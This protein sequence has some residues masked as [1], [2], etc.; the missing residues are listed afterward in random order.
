MNNP[1]CYI[2]ACFLDFSKVF[3]QIVVD[4]VITKLVDLGVV[5]KARSVPQGTKRGL[6]LIVVIN[7]INDLK[8][9]LPRCS[10]KLYVDDITV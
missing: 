8:L 9:A 5:C 7:V 10:L 1:C 2:R 6:I 3:D 4:N